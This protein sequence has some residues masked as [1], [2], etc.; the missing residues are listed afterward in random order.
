MDFLSGFISN[1]L[2]TLIV[3]PIDCVKTKYQVTKQPV[4]TIVKSV[5]KENGYRGFYRG[6]APSISTYSVFWAVF[7]QSKTMNIQYSENKKVNTFLSSYISANIATTIANPLFVLKAR[8]QTQNTDRMYI[9]RELNKQKSRYW[10]GLY[11]SYCNNIKIGFQFPLYEYLK[12]KTNNVVFS[13][14]SSKCICSTL[15]YPMDLIRVHQRVSDDKK[16]IFDICK[17]IYYNEGMKGFYK[18][19]LLYNSVSLLNF[20]CMM[21]LMENIKYN[22]NV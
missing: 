17:K 7:F 2:S 12:N 5:Y 4:M 22:F 15:L 21:F 10:S 14:F 13:S 6:F 1:S 20:T 18:G 19:V 9:I 3:Q 8:F 16:T 11:M